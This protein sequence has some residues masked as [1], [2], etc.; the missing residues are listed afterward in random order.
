VRRITQPITPV[1]IVMIKPIAPS[2]SKSPTSV[3]R[4]A[5]RNGSMPLYMI[6]ALVNSGHC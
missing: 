3:P 5:E 1:M 2:Q 6:G 4:L